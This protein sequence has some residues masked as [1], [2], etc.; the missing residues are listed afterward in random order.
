MRIKRLEL[1]GFKSFVDPTVVD[2]DSPIVGVVGPNGCGK[3]NIVDAIRWVMGE[4]SAKSLRGRAMEDVIFNGSE[5]R[6]P[7]GMAEVSLTF[8]TEDGIAPADYA[9]FSEI[10]ISRRLYRSGDSEYLIN[11]VPSRLRDVVDLFLGTGVGH[12]AY[13]VI[14]QG[15]ID[16]VI[17]A[18]PED[19]RLLIEEAA[20]VSKFKARKEAALRKMEGTEQNLARLKDIFNEVNRQINS[21]DRQVKKAERYKELKNELRELEL[22]LASIHHRE[23]S[24]EVTELKALLED[25]TAKE[26]GSGAQLAAF[27]ADLERGRLELVEK[28]REYNTLQERFFEVSSRLNLL[29]AQQEFRDKERKGLEELKQQSLLEIEEMKG[30]L[31][32][33]ELEKEEQE[34]NRAAVEG[35]AAELQLLETVEKEFRDFESGRD[36]VLEN[37][38]RLKEEVHQLGS[39]LVRLEGEKK[40]YDERKVTL[41]GQIAGVEVE[42]EETNRRFREQR[43]LLD[44]KSALLEQAARQV[45]SLKEEIENARSELAGQHEK[46][47]ILSRELDLRREELLLK[48]SRLKSLLDLERNFEGYEEGVRTVLKIK[49]ERGREDSIFGV[50]ADFI[51]TAPRYEMA[52]SAALGEKLQYVIVKSHEEGVE[53]INTL[54]AESSGRSTFIPLEVRDRSIDDFPSHGQKGV[55]GPLLDLVRL[56][57]D[58]QRIGQYLLGDV[59]LVESLQDALSLW[60]S[61]GHKKTLVTLDGEVVDPFGVVSG[62]TSGIRGKILLEKKREIKELRALTAELEE[63]IGLKEDTLS[64]LEGTLSE[65]TLTLEQFSRRSHEEEVKRRTLETE[66]AH[67]EEEFRRLEEDFSKYNEELIRLRSDLEKTEDLIG[68]C[69]SRRLELAAKRREEEAEIAAREE[70]LSEAEQRLKASQER[71]T[72]ARVQAAAASERKAMAERERERLLQIEEELHQRIEQKMAAITE[73]HQKMS[74]LDRSVEESSAEIQVLKKTADELAVTQENARSR[75]ESLAAS[76]QEKESR[77]RDLRK[78]TDLAK[79]HTGDLRVTLSRAET[80]LTHL[81]RQIL[82]KYSVDLKETAATFAGTEIDKTSEEARLAELKEKIERLG[83]VNLGAIPEYEKLRTRQEFLSKQIEDLENSLASLKKAIHRINQTTKKRFEETFALV[84][85]RFQTLFPRLFQG[86]RAELRFSQDQDLL[87]AGVELLV[88]PPGKKLS[89][90]GLLSGGEKALSAVAFVFSIFL[91][92]PSP[93]CI[94][95]EVDAPLDDANT[96]RFHRLISEMTSRTQFI[97]ITHNRRTMEKADLLYGVT[98]QEPGV[99]QLVSVRLSE[100]LKLAS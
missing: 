100:G 67:C 38:D 54:K 78:E 5:K 35:A 88:Q 16:Y 13:S 21:L 96:E 74:L 87:Q 48:R 53:A 92:K 64:Q 77:I 59:I 22:K 68:Q 69:E 17:N 63:E 44:Q 72:A 98:M 34:K 7:L 6:P 60:R 50:V 37:L 84:N 20:G 27:E 24:R 26:T 28:D 49:K 83:D 99:S 80:E 56:K 29:Q 95:D 8:S 91:V 61:N 23:L 81:E 94:L 47:E 30:R 89:H 57:P 86:G 52:V 97:L 19:R 70:R 41:K 18:K 73:A 2:F 1:V 85:E 46:R 65:L 45:Q 33:L 15:K 55:V 36:A 3:S 31:A 42:S 93:F 4:M 66:R 43:S 40:L 79:S 10:T 58:Y 82:E 32:T 25:W 14:E 51:E 11:K 9:G 39:Q 71:L 76:I 75:Y 90:V 12:K 62:G